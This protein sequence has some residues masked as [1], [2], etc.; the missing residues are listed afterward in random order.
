MVVLMVDQSAELKVDP[1]DARR[2]EKLA[3]TL[4]WKLAEL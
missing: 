2:A 1:R 4:E 3:L